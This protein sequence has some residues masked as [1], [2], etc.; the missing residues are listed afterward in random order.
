MSIDPVPRATNFT[1][2]L[3]GKLLGPPVTAGIT[4][5][6]GFMTIRQM[7]IP[8]EE[9]ARMRMQGHH[10]ERV[11]RHQVLMRW[12]SS[13]SE[14]QPLDNGN[15]TLHSAPSRVMKDA[16]LGRYR[17]R[18]KMTAINPKR[19]EV[20]S[21]IEIGFEVVEKMPPQK[22]IDSAAER[23]EKERAEKK[24]KMDEEEERKRHRGM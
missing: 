20:L 19:G 14:M 21:C 10:L 11:N 16:P 12:Q 4:L 17:I 5:S 1:F 7:N 13:E 8:D 9:I 18:Q 2:S 15:F 22:D 23:G 3:F 24:R 6:E